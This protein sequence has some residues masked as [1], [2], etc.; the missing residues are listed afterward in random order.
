MWKLQRHKKLYFL[1]YEIQRLEC[2]SNIPTKCWNFL[3]KNE[4]CGNISHW[5]LQNR[6][7]TT[8]VCLLHAFMRLCSLKR[9]VFSNRKSDFSPGCAN[10]LAWF[11]WKLAR[12]TSAFGTIGAVKFHAN[13]CTAVG[14][15]PPKY[16]KFHLLV[17]NRK[18]EPLH[19]FG[20]C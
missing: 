17:N 8:H 20:E 15:R 9:Q 18:G 1:K 19:R 2:Y 7:H 13:R 16:Q 6:N 5:K 11:T 3:L 10:S 4:K 12:A 14:T